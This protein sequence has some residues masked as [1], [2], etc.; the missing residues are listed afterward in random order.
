MFGFASLIY[1]FDTL[2][3]LFNLKNK[4]TTKALPIT[5]PQSL[6]KLGNPYIRVPS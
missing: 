1:Y 4:N 3:G 6:N 5:N 2:K